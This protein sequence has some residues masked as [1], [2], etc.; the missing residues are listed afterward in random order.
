MKQGWTMRS[1]ACFSIL[2]TSALLLSLIGCGVPKTEHDKVV[3]AL[4]QANQE[5]T[6]LASQVDQLVKEKDSL[7][8]QVAQL[9]KENA[10]LK[11]KMAKP[12]AKAPA[13][14]AAKAPVKKK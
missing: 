4:E 8:Q 3:K 1:Q 5:K 6:N 9:Q 11:A 13:K 12:A 7:A 10:D 14:P 2:M